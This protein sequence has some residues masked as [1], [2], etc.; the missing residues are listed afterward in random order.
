MISKRKRDLI[1]LYTPIYNVIID[2]N[3]KNKGEQQLPP[4]AVFRSNATQFIVFNGLHCSEI[5]VISAAHSL[6]MIDTT[7]KYKHLDDLRQQCKIQKELY[8]FSFWSSLSLRNGGIIDYNED[9]GKS[10]HQVYYNLGKPVSFLGHP[11]INTDFKNKQYKAPRLLTSLQHTIAG[12]EA[13]TYY[14]TMISCVETLIRGLY[15]YGI[16][17]TYSKTW[18]SF[19]FESIFGHLSHLLI[20]ICQEAA[21]DENTH[22]FI[23]MW[24]KDTLKLVLQHLYEQKR[25]LFAP[26]SNRPQITK[27][28][29]NIMIMRSQKKN[30][31]EAEYEFKFSLPIEFEIENF[32]FISQIFDL[33]FAEFSKMLRIT[34][35]TEFTPK[36]IQTILLNLQ[37]VI[38]MF[39]ESLGRPLN[40]RVSEQ[41]GD[42]FVCSA[43]LSHE[44]SDVRQ[45]TIQPNSSTL[46]FPNMFN[47]SLSGPEK[48][49]SIL[50]E[51]I[52]NQMFNPQ[53][54][55]NYTF[56][57]ILNFFKKGDFEIILRIYY[58]ICFTINSFIK[59]KNEM[60]NPIR[61]MNPPHMSTYIDINIEDSVLSI[62]NSSELILD[63]EEHSIYKFSRHKHDL[64]HIT[65]GFKIFYE[66]K[67][68]KT[69][70]ENHEEDH[71]DN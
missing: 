66:H 32:T 12:V 9:Y 33:F 37:C 26:L 48:I 28:E 20:R 39:R 40:F 46:I 65:D 31:T 60:I 50:I 13:A 41:I 59:S 45:I 22:D 21:K 56:S 36:N 54:K 61:I 55:D 30:I 43:L 24:F 34:N 6:G 14:D 53:Y 52:T 15:Q 69:V 49:F 17:A 51:F 3:L 1:D 18:I 63:D 68:P 5:E 16:D 7:A 25:L 19:R 8:S 57:Q 10:Y 11:I 67:K 71:D 42:L 4:I 2:P 29:K 27:E 23:E 35:Q 62:S 38:R 47:E 44:L 64:S 70:D 58:S